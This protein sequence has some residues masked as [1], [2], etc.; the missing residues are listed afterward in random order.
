MRRSPLAPRKRSLARVSPGNLSVG[1]RVL[2]LN[3]G[4]GAHGS[5]GTIHAVYASGR[6]RVDLDKGGWRNL[7]PS[8]VKVI[9]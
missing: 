9:Q 1:Q 5:Q 3:D 2:V 4:D 7:P 6:C 8:Q